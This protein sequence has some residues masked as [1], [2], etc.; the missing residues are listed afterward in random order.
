MWKWFGHIWA[1][2]ASV[3][4]RDSVFLA[5]LFGAFLAF[6]VYGASKA[7]LR[8]NRARKNPIASE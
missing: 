6:G 2:E 7:A 1:G 3:P 5:A 8:L 4:S